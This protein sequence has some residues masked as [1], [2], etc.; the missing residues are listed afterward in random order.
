MAAFAAI[1]FPYCDLH[2]QGRMDNPVKGVC[3]HTIVCLSFRFLSVIFQP[4]KVNAAC[5]LKCEKLKRCQCC[6]WNMSITRALP[7]FIPVCTKYSNI[8]PPLENVKQHNFT[9]ARPTL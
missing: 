8:S 3:N 7:S 5:E 2:G 6:I 9:A 1:Y 4:F